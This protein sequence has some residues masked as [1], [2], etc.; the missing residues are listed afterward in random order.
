MFDL[1]YLDAQMIVVFG[2]LFFAF[3]QGMKKIIFKDF[4]A[5]FEERES[6]T[7]GALDRSKN[8]NEEAVRLLSEYR[9]EIDSFRAK[10]VAR[11]D[12]Q[13]AGAKKNAADLIKHAE[14]KVA[15]ETAASKDAQARQEQEDS[16]TLESQSD[17]LARLAAMRILE[18]TSKP[19]VA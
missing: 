17:E 2:F 5:L 3:W 18:G 7:T 14:D 19:S 10:L 16:R 9:A 13:I 4:L 11:K 8:L 1:V 6:A 15:A 12:E